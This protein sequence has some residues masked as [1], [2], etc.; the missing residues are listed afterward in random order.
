MKHTLLLLLLIGIAAGTLQ[1]QSLDSIPTSTAATERVT[2]IEGGYVVGGIINAFFFSANS[3]PTLSVSHGV[4]WQS[5][6]TGAL[7]A[8]VQFWQDATILPIYLTFRAATKRG[9]LYDVRTGYALGFAPSETDVVDYNYR[10]GLYG[11]VGYGR[12]VYTADRLEVAVKLGYNFQQVKLDYVPFD[13]A[14]RVSSGN[15]YH[16]LALSADMTF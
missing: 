6:Y 14:E 13:G 12:R 16:Y 8:G 4:R 5:R 15:N 10:G 3:G 2:T 11:Y 1:A 9:G 7:G